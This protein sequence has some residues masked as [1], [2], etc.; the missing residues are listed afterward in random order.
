VKVYPIYC[1]S[2]GSSDEITTFGVDIPN[3]IA[4]SGSDKVLVGTDGE[5]V[6]LFLTV[7]DFRF[8]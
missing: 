2:V 5:S 3:S 1:M 8:E 7:S 6:D 4:T